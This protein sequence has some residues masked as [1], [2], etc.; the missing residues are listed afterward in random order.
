MDNMMA[1]KSARP[2]AILFSLSALST[3]LWIQPVSAEEFLCDAQ[4]ASSQ[5]LPVLDKSCPIGRGLWGKQQP[6]N[7]A[8][9]F[10]IQCGLL[11][12]PLSLAQAKPIYQHISTD[13]WM[14]H[15]G[16]NVRCLIGPY[17]D[18]QEANRDLTS[19]RT[20]RAY[21]EAFIREVVP[22]V[23]NPPVKAQAAKPVAATKSQPK[24]ASSQKTTVFAPAK[25]EPVAKSQVSA[26]SSAKP[27]ANMDIDLRLQGEVS[28]VEYVVPYVTNSDHQFYMEHNKAWNRLNYDDATLVCRQLG[29]KLPTEV[30]WSRFIGSDVM[31]KDKWPMHLPY[32]GSDRHGLFTSGKVTKLKGTSLLNVMC[33][34]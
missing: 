29:M 33:T 21:R 1:V 25:S 19:L 22:G 18:F 34:K 28:G 5:Q 17:K 12:R 24:T 16:N 23:A 20:Q 6:K 32:W 15:E 10:W 7:N 4:Q 3:S 2:W 11:N 14:K 30:E 9:L 8:S 31:E 27:I 26:T 13:V